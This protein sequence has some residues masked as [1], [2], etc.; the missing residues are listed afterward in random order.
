MCMALL[1][2]FLPHFPRTLQGRAKSSPASR[3]AS[4]LQQLRDLALPDL[5]ALLGGLLPADFFAKAP[6]AQAKRERIYPPITLFWAFLF[7]VLN[8]AM[9]CQEVVG[10]VRAWLI[11]RHRNKRRPAMG[12][13]SYCEAR[14]GL[15]KSPS[16]IEKELLMHAI[17][18]NAIRA[19]ILQSATSHQ[20]ELGRISFKGAVDL[21]RQWL[22]QAA[23]CHDRPRKLAR[24]HAELLEAIASVQNSLRPDRREPRA[25]KR[26]PKTFQMLTKPRHKF[27]EIPHRDRYRLVA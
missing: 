24:W 3:I 10:K 4:G 14:S 9:P 23:A 6:D 21:L 27:H 17:A 2:C 26:R 12:A 5:A 1:T 7:Q 15:S 11:T 25:V 22:P 16:M 13:S 19:L 8:P 18:Y 20:Q